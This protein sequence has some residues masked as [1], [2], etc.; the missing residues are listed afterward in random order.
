M[1]LAVAINSVVFWTKTPKSAEQN[2]YLPQEESLHMLTPLL[3]T[4][5]ADQ[6]RNLILPSKHKP[7]GWKVL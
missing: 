6:V 4:S 1:G 7:I 2:M 5:K 3:L